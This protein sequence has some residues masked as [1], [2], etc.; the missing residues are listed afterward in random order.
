M[1]LKE[2]CFAPQPIRPR[3]GLAAALVAAA[4]A[5][6]L[7][8]Q[9][10]DELYR[11]GVEARHSG[12][13]ERAAE[14]LRRVTA[15]EPDNSD[16]R[17][18]LGLALLALGRLDE[19]EAAFRETLRIAPGYADARI[20]LAR[21][22][23]RRGDRAA[24][25]AALEPVDPSNPEAQQLRDALRA[26]PSAPGQ[27]RIDAE[28]SYS[29][30]EGPR[31]DWFE[32]SV[33]LRYE[34]TEDTAL[35]G[36][37][38]ISDR[39]HASDVYVEGRIDRRIG[40][41]SGAYLA[42]GMT[43]NADFRPEWQIS[44]GGFARLRDGPHATVITIDGRQA[45]FPVGTIRTLTPGIEQY[46]AGGRLWLTGRWINIFDENGRHHAGWLARGDVMAS[47]RLR[48]FAGLADAPDTSEGVVIGAFSLFGGV[49][50]DISARNSVRASVAHENRDIGPDRFQ[51]SFGT[52]VRF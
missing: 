33:R 12:D 52:G 5:A 29:D 37:V 39:G 25:L 19:A 51:L 7:A 28:L 50:Y 27:T 6:P 48:L 22:A 21:I 41:G 24:A 44:A 32:G 47:E 15:A 38:E 30:V 4:L 40:R 43:P 20:G 46:L 13:P 34:V 3:H 1:A 10:V 45:W 11:Q 26:D 9:P 16:A 2:G 17:L 35:A 23:Q 14:I 49:S 8:A 36:G 18:Q 31:S 42:L